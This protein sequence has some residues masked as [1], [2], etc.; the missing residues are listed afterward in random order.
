MAMTLRTT[1]AV[2]AALA[3]LAERQGVS[4]HEAAMRAILRDDADTRLEDDA[5]EAYKRV[6]HEYRDALDRL[7]SV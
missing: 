6:A 1:S 3:R 2:E 4:K 5:L 7:G